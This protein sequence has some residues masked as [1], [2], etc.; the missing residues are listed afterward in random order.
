MDFKEIAEYVG[1]SSY[2]KEF[3]DIYLRIDDVNTDFCNI[4]LF[5]KY[6]KEYEILKEHYGTVVDSISEIIKDENLYVYGKVFCEYA[7]TATTTEVRCTPMPILDGTK[8]RD[9]FA[10][11]VMY[12]TFPCAV[13]VYKERGY[14]DED[15]KAAFNQVYLAIESSRKQLGRFAMM[16]VYYNWSMLYVYGEIFPCGGFTFQLKKFDY[17]AV[18]LRNRVTLELVPVITD[19][20][21]HRDGL[22]LGS[23]GAEDEEGS[24]ITDFTETE[25]VYICNSIKRGRVSRELAE[26]KKSEWECI[27]KRGDYLLAV[28]IPRNT[29]VTHEAVKR[30]FSAALLQAKKIFPDYNV[31][32]LMCCSWLLDHTLEE[33]LGENSRI[34]GFGNE[35]IRFPVKSHGNEHKLFVFP[36]FKGEL[37]ELPEDTS[38]QR[39]IKKLLLSG[40]HIYAVA[41]V[42]TDR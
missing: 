15:I 29:D 35:F 26:Y 25:D 11:P 2:P 34:V 12:S 4:T 6:E 42:Y 41:G 38:L 28:H 22:A 16:D 27:V 30:D 24:F 8:K 9:F 33:L 5:E 21:F 3:D 23:V 17:T 31:S 7:K 10:L 19:G 18:I 37:D 32:H 13:R 40:G 14:S 39:K 1:V 20:K 36:G